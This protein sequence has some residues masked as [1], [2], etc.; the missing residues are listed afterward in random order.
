MIRRLAVA[1]VLAIGAAFAMAPEAHAGPVEVSAQASSARVEVGEPFSVELRAMTERGAGSPSDPELRAPAGFSVAGPSIST[2]SIVQIFN[3]RTN[4]KTGIGATWQLTASTPGHFTIPAP[5]VT[6]NGQRLQANPIPID[7]VPSTGTRRAPSGMSLL[8]GGPGFSWPLSP[9]PRS[10]EPD[11]DEV[12]ESLARDLSMD[13]APDAQLFLRAVVDKTSAVVGEQVTVSFYAYHRV[14]FEMTERHEASL[15]DFVRVPLLKNPGSDPPVYAQA[16]GHKF[17]VRL[18]DRIALFPVRAGALHTGAMQARFSGRSVG[19]RVLRSS[20]DVAITVTEP[21]IAGRPAG[22]SLG[23]VGQFTLTATVEP[24]SIDQGGAVSVTLKLAGKG[25]LPETLRVPA[26]AGVDWLD[27]E[28]K[29]AIEP[30]G[31]VVGGYRSF[32]YV[33]RIAEAGDVDL[34]KV[35][36]AAWDPVAKR[37][38]VASANLGIIRVAASAPVASGSAAPAPNATA[39]ADDSRSPFATLPPARHELTSAPHAEAPPLEGAPFWW[40]LVTPPG[41]V[42]AS[43]VGLRAA[44]RLK[45]RRREISTSSTSLADAALRDLRE[46]EGRG[47]ARGV[48]AGAERALHH[49]IEAFTGLRSRGVL[50]GDLTRELEARG[51]PKPLAE[52]TERALVRSD[53]LRFDPSASASA[54]ADLGAETRSILRAL[55]DVGDAP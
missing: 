28:K 44:A 33:V 17:A 2:Q 20:N 51:V 41:L 26:R 27:P 52:R 12:E 5:S 3:G 35:D 1:L 31:N 39:T 30:T 53:S 14:N 48:A 36:L 7:V 11:L 24:R 47:D 46:A 25:N 21:P 38:Q 32:G 54:I 40:T 10:A 19:S 13:R 55:E 18:L 49:G 15:D 34:G 45:Q 29:S 8:P 16:G 43:S 50:L 6:V 4:A 23:D 37:Y 42:L 22:Y 9:Q